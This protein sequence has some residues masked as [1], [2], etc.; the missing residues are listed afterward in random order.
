MGRVIVGYGYIL[1]VIKN[2]LWGGTET[3][4]QHNRSQAKT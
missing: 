4:L 2:G 3:W 1:L